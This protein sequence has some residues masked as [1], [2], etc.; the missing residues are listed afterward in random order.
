LPKEKN[1]GE[2]DSKRVEPRDEEKEQRKKENGE[3]L[4]FNFI[5]SEDDGE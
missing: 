3:G 2:Q 1:Q 5:E 4:G